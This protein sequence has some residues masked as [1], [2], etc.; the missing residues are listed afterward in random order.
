MQSKMCVVRN[1]QHHERFL[2]I[3]TYINFKDWTDDT[4]SKLPIL[5]KWVLEVYVYQVIQ[6]FRIYC[7]I[8]GRIRVR[9][10]FLFVHFKIRSNVIF[11]LSD[12]LQI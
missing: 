1:Y 11:V 10:A 9:M 4:F 7:K 12:N 3:S 5:K 6:P 2:K 8:Y